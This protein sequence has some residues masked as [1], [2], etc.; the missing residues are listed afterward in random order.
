MTSLLGSPRANALSETCSYESRIGP[1]YEGV[2][3]LTPKITTPFTRTRAGREGEIVGGMTYA[4][5]RAPH[6]EGMHGTGSVL[7]KKREMTIRACGANH[8]AGYEGIFSPKWAE[9]RLPYPE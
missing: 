4:G 6:G 1:P 5:R 8:T 2:R 9:R 7:G 3:G